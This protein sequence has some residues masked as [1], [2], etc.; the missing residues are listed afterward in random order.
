[1]PNAFRLP[2]PPSPP[3]GTF[4]TV[5]DETL[6]FPA[7]RL[8]MGHLGEDDAGIE[9][10]NRYVTSISDDRLRAVANHVRAWLYSGSD[11]GD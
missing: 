4:R 2:T 10:D 1:M 5:A 8:A 3:R 11:G 6:D 9:M 7:V